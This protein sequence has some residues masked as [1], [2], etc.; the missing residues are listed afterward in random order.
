MTVV[1]AQ[2]VCFDELY[3]AFGVDNGSSRE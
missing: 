3:V 1:H 2:L